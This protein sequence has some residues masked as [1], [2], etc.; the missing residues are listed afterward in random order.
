MWSNE[1]RFIKTW[2]CDEISADALLLVCLSETCWIHLD[3]FGLC[4]PSFLSE[5]VEN[6]FYKQMNEPLS[7]S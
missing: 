4:D 5:T 3:P 7:S 2:L 1:Q 6:C